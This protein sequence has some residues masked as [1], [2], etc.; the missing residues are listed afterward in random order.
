MAVVE[1]GPPAQ[2]PVPPRRRPQRVAVAAICASAA[3]WGLGTVLSKAAVDSALDP[4]PLLAVQLA[5][6]VVF[7]GLLV[8]WRA[9]PA[10]VDRT[11][12]RSGAA[13]LLEPGLSY[14]VALVGLGLTTAGSASVI[15][16]VEPVVTAALAWVVLRERVTARASVCMVVVL[17]GV[18]LVGADTS[19]GGGTQALLGNALVLL[20]VV[21]A[22][23]YSVASARAARRVPPLVL[24][25]LQHSWAL[26]LVVPL[27]AVA[28]LAGLSGGLPAGLGVQTW[29]LAVLSGVVN[30]AVPFWL[31]L[32]AVRTLPVGI[33]AQF[34]ALV[35]V[36]GV[37]GGV[38]LLGEAVSAA[39][40][41]GALLVVLALVGLARTVGVSA[42]A[43]VRTTRASP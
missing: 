3:T 28:V 36:V 5:A 10:S 1:S 27:W 16:S 6:S 30:Y 15:G 43:P 4:L 42:S 13:G 31:Y 2:A 14:P 22:A 11:L 18:A 40:A 21:F 25:L 32:V 37:T 39:Q 20:G 19:T 8:A 17:L 7:L 35:P 41:A 29:A 12:L 34:L 26:L 24:A 23:V 38:V 33:A 9:R